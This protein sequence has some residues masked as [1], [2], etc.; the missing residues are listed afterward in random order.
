MKIV[1]IGDGRT[2]YSLAEN[3][4]QDKNNYVTIIDKNTDALRETIESID[5]R[6]ITGNGVRTNTL[7]D[8][9]VR[10][11]DLLI[12][13][14][15][16][17]EVNMLC[18]LTAKRLGAEHTIARIRDHEY[19][20]ELLQLKKDL[21]FDMVINPEQAVAGEIAKLIGFPPAAD[22]E[23]FVEGRVQMVEIKVA[24]GMP[25][26]DIPLKDI[27]N[28]IFSS[29]LIG[30]VSRGNDIIIPN[31]DT[32]IRENDTIY[33][34][35]HPSNVYRFCT[36]IGIYVRKIKSAMIIGGG[37]V[38]YY[39][40]KYLCEIDIHVKIMEKDRDRCVKLAELLPDALVINRDGSD[41]IA[42]NSENM[43]SMD[44]FISVTDSDEENLMTALLA[45]RRGVP[46]VVA[47]I[48]RA[49]YAEIL[50]DIGIDNLVSDLTVTINYI[51][52]Y[53]R[54]LRNAMGNSVNTLHRIIGGQ[55][56]AIEFTATQSA[57]MLN[58]PLKNLRLIKNVLIV[59]IVRKNNI[60]IPHGSDAIKLHDYVVIMTKGTKLSDLND[61]IAAGPVRE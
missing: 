59:V 46:K 58:T 45:K 54:G 12:A 15:S 32:V 28:K 4:S 53:I 49:S 10:E 21:G 3:L 43:R 1:I 14:T 27:S 20:D 6:Y 26:V 60:I 29:I 17:D 7:L 57:M 31:G 13:V 56:E 38:G 23:L 39:L 5:V 2:G 44:S 47:K 25:L 51:L 37:R 55:A 50:G 36:L 22:V 11:T 42:L 61:I 48:N 30:A 40:A 9:G 18:C 16:S 33:I 24:A 52:R 8:A 19:A 34:I 41:H 35:G